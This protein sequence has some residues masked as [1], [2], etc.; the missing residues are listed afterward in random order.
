MPR[1]PLGQGIGGHRP[2]LRELT[3]NTSVVASVTC[4]VTVRRDSSHRFWEQKQGVVWISLVRHSGGT[5]AVG[6]MRGW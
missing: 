4:V 3:F 6:L 2:D 5:R 1:T